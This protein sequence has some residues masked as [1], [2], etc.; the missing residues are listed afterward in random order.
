MTKEVKFNRST[1]DW[2]MYLGG[3][4]VGSCSTPQEARV[5]LDRLAY[6]QLRRTA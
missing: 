3:E 6:E 2:D 5:E 4:Y 1:R